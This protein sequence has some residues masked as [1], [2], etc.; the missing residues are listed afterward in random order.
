MAQH[1]SAIESGTEIPPFRSAT[2]FPIKPKPEHLADLY[3]EII[4]ELKNS[5]I[6]RGILREDLNKK[7]QMIADMRAE[8]ARLESNLAIEAKTRI[9]LHRMNEQLFAALQEIEGVAEDASAVVINAHQTP[10]TG[11]GALIEKLKI[12][13]K[14]WRAL[15]LQYRS[16]L[17]PPKGRSSDD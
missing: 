4:T 9:Q 15:K 5:N 8:I 3:P 1:S 17:V 10:R 11:L 12:L 2:D 7:K 16:G 14:K 13:V 6:A